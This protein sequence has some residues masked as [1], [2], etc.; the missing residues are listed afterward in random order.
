MLEILQKPK[1][2]L[3]LSEFPKTKTHSSIYQDKFHSMLPYHLYIFT[4]SSWGNNKTA[5][6]E[7]L[8]SQAGYQKV[9]ILLPD[10]G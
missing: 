2:I 10:L 5:C 7:K 9:D 4:D 3:K 1:V 8:L 6:T